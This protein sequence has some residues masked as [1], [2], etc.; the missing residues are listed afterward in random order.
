MPRGSIAVLMARISAISWALRDTG[1]KGLLERDPIPCSAEINPRWRAT[2]PYRLLDSELRH[3]VSRHT[4]RHMEIA[5]RALGIGVL[6][7]RPAANG[8]YD[9][10][11]APGET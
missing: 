2:T 11:H 1:K 10:C 9:T 4:H 7:D 3:R 5:G 6:G 8:Q